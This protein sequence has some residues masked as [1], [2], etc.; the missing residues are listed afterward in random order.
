MRVR[1]IKLLDLEG[2]RKGGH[3]CYQLGEFRNPQGRSGWT[4][5]ASRISRVVIFFRNDLPRIRR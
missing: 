5:P 2:K 1:N 4:A 3:T